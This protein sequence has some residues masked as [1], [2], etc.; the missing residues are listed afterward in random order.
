M[1]SDCA[2][3]N[4]HYVVIFVVLFSL[5]Y[6]LAAWYFSSSYEPVGDGLEYQRLYESIFIRV[7]V[8]GLESVVPYLMYACKWMGLDYRKFLLLFS[9]LWLPVAIYFI[10]ATRANGCFLIVAAFFLSWLFFYSAYFLMRQFAGAL[11]FSLSLMIGSRT[12]KAVLL[13][14]AVCSH[15]AIVL[16]IPALFAPVRRVVLDGRLFI[17]IFFGSFASYVLGSLPEDRIAGWIDWLSGYFSWN[18]ELARK[19]GYYSSN[20]SADLALSPSVLFVVFVSGAILLLFRPSARIKGAAVETLLSIMLVSS[21]ACF[22]FSANPVLANRVGFMAY[23][24]AVPYFAFS[25]WKIDP[26]RRLK[27][28]WCRS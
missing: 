4:T 17:V 1:K 8:Y 23:F 13:C 19:F 7:N 10:W 27:F 15:L 18:G 20:N 12:F 6:M 22:V 9:L 14:L 5:A 21:V 2:R 26:V 25:L 16:W 24:F 3:G 11:F 28:M